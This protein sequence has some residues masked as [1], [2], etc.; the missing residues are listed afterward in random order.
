M[1]IVT[2]LMNIFERGH[3]YLYQRVYSNNCNRADEVTT[4]HQALKCSC[5][6]SLTEG[7]HDID[8]GC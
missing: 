2:T 7:W 5:S 3:T 8:S 6:E 4:E 1:V